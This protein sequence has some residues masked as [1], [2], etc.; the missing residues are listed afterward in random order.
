MASL[1]PDDYGMPTDKRPF[2]RYAV[3]GCIAIVIVIFGYA[4]FDA[5][6]RPEENAAAFQRRYNECHPTA[7]YIDRWERP[8]C[9]FMQDAKAKGRSPI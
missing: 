8:N 6:L 9:D 7:R 4:T 1:G 5:W 3:L 2:P